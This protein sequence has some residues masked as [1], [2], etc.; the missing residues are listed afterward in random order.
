VEIVV[1][2]GKR[3]ELLVEIV[4]VVGKDGNCL[5]ILLLFGEKRRAWAML[6]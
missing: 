5:M 3:R 6:R 4:V 1:V 2:D